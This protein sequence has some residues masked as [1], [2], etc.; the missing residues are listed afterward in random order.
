MYTCVRASS[1]EHRGAGVVCTYSPD[2]RGPAQYT[3]C[4]QA[5]IKDDK[6]EVVVLLALVRN[7]VTVN[8]SGSGRFPAT[9]VSGRIR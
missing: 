6:F 3:G 2:C 7:K 5:T 8:T 9:M 4:T 1:F